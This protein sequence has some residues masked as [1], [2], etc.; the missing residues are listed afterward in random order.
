MITNVVT[1]P[2]DELAVLLNIV[3]KQEFAVLLAIVS[4]PFLVTGLYFGWRHR[5]W[6]SPWPGIGEDVESFE[7]LL[8]GLQLIT[9]PAVIIA[10]LLVSGFLAYRFWPE[11][12]TKP[13][14]PD[15]CACRSEAKPNASA[16]T[17]GCREIPIDRE[18]GGALTALT[19]AINGVT[20][21]LDGSGSSE[22]ARTLLAIETALRAIA[23]SMA[24]SGPATAD[25]L[26]RLD[27]LETALRSLAE[28]AAKPSPATPQLLERLDAIEKALDAI[29]NRRGELP[30]VPT[31]Q[32]QA[33][34]DSLVAI[35]SALG[36]LDG[37]AALDHLTLIEVILSDLRYPSSPTPCETLKPFAPLAEPT[38]SERYLV[39]L[40]RQRGLTVAQQYRGTRRQIFFDPQANQPSEIGT[41][42]LQLTGEDARR[43]G[44]ALA[45]R[46]EA[47]TV[48]DGANADAMARQR[49]DAIADYLAQHSPVPVVGIGL[50][51]PSGAASEPYRRIVRIDLLEPCD[52]RATPAAAVHPGPKTR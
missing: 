1:H 3:S 50:A 52:G 14:N 48:S 12:V 8:T 9:F 39:N 51:P 21:K 18:F 25:L 36:K 28:A 32:L 31:S 26:D 11:G 23:E 27:K 22:M 38:Q 33:I 47:D 6:A 42:L 2:L 41:R 13:S 37:A 43:R 17:P 20:N 4:I 5:H 29:A 35:Q 7:D 16:C 44:L 34:V 49:A 24:K 40:A 45:I 19:Q 15:P 10:L 30:T 46:A